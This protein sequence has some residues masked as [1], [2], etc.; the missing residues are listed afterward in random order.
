MKS[1]VIFGLHAVGSALKNDANNIRR[2]LVEK[3]RQDKRLTELLA[4]AGQ[5]GVQVEEVSKQAL[6]RFTGGARHQSVAADYV[7]A[8]VPGEAQLLED[9][10][11]RERPWLLLVLDGVQDPHNLGACLR[12]ADAAGVDAVIC[13]RDRATGLTPVVMKVAAGAAGRVPFYQVTNLRRTLEALQQAGVWLIGTSDKASD[14]YAAIDYTTPVAIVMGSEGK[15][16]RRLTAEA[17]DS[18][19]RI[20]MAGEVS[21]LNVSVATGVLLFEVVRQRNAPSA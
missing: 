14:D 17:C 11:A 8:E 4:L 2:L 20:P 10:E 5:K 13:P 21:S 19:V 3:R 15:G 1:S 16:I 6:D 12:T 9:L 18:L 7:L